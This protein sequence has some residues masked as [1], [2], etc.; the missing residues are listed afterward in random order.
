MVR[1]LFLL[2][3]LLVPRIAG[4]P[5]AAEAT[6]DIS[7]RTYGELARIHKLIEAGN[8][9]EAKRRLSGMSVEASPYAQAI[10]LQTQGVL[11][12]RAREY[13]QAI[14]ALERCLSIEALPKE[15]TRNALSVLVQAQAASE[16]YAEAARNL[17]LWF[18]LS[19]KP[20]VEEY[21]LAGAIYAQVG[22]TDDAVTALKKALSGSAEARE[23]WYRQLAALYAGAK[24][25]EAA[26]ELLAIMVQ[27]F[28]DRKAYWLQLAVSY[29]ALGSDTKALATLE[30]AYRR[31]LP[32]TEP[33]LL[34]LAASLMRQGLPYR[35][36]E[37]L[38]RSLGDGSLSPTAHHWERLSDAWVRARE[39]ALALAALGRALELEPS[40]ERHLR[41]A[42]LALEAEDWELVLASA[43][44][45]LSADALKAPGTAHVLFG[46]AHH[47]LGHPD[48]ALEAFRRAAEQDTSRDQAR[49]WIAFITRD[50]E[51]PPAA[52]QQ[53]VTTRRIP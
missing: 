33:E 22:R 7:E 52:S 27:R 20:T 21:G 50:R 41:R 28:P 37:L 32:F 3:V 1:C 29:Q 11:Y 19:G 34:Q 48:D 2:A 40:A 8:Y 38:A 6:G 47:R 24:R 45:A 12:A 26:A 43:Q 9:D 10:L 44:A 13:P 49:A 18:A 30:L 14:A 51:P 23:V 53:P 4:G 36:G 42:R 25:H 35:A 5:L 15:A 31:G 39:P 46:I 16:R 17:D